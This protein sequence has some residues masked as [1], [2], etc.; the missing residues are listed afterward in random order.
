M[1]PASAISKSFLLSGQFN[2]IARLPNKHAH[3]PV[4]DNH[5]FHHGRI[6]KS[7]PPKATSDGSHRH[8]GSAV[9]ALH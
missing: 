1:S 3:N 5:E 7:I 2:V 4:H 9:P 6:K 8:C